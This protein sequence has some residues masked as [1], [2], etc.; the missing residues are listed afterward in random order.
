MRY[1]FSLGASLFARNIHKVIYFSPLDSSLRLNLM[2]MKESPIDVARKNGNQATIALL[3]DFL[4]TPEGSSLAAEPFSSSS[5]FHLM[6][7]SSSRKEP[8]SS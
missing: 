4:A 8:T 1:L 5:I 7:D 3:Q 2:F 6:L